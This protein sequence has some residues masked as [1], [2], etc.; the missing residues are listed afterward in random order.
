LQFKKTKKYKT[1][2]TV[3]KNVLFDFGHRLNDKIIKLQRFG[4][5]ILLTSSGKR[6]EEDRNPIC[7]APG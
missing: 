3:H 5:W 6:G 1:V 2:S 4:G 7:C